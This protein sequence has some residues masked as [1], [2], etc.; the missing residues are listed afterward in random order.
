MSNKI[1]ILGERYAVKYLKS[2]SYSILKTNFRISGSEVDI[3]ATKEDTLVGVEVKTS[4]NRLLEGPEL[5]VNRLKYARI[6]LGLQVYA[7]RH[8]IQDSLQVD[9]VSV[10]L[11]GV[12]LK[13]LKHFKNIQF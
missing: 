7:H 2:H 11:Q 3:I 12:R 13:K 5:A 10:I 6:I 4:L 8:N 9:V 1:G